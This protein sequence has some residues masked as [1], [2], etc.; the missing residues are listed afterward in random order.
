[1]FPPRTAALAI[2][3]SLAACGPRIDGDVAVNETE[4]EVN[5]RSLKSGD[6]V[7]VVGVEVPPVTATHKYVTLKIPAENIGEG[8]HKLEVQVQ[9]GAK[10]KSKS[11]DVNVPAS[12]LAPYL[13][14]FC[15]SHKDAPGRSKISGAAVPG[16]LKSPSCPLTSG[17][18]VA[19]RVETHADAVLTQDGAVIAHDPSGEA[20]LSLQPALK[21]ASLR[22]VGDTK[23]GGEFPFDSVLSVSRGGKTQSFPLHVELSLRDLRKV[24]FE[25]VL[26]V[27]PG[28]PVLWPR[29][30]STGKPR[31]VAFALRT[32][33]VTV[34]GKQRAVRPEAYA[35]PLVAGT[36]H[37]ADEVDRFAVATPTDVTKLKSCTGYR[38]ISGS[39]GVRNV[40]FKFGF[41]VKVFD[42]EGK[43]VAERS[44]TKPAKTRCPDYLSGKPGETKV[45]VWGPDRE[46]V[47]QWLESLVR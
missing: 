3:L 21:R 33:E 16:Y 47:Q 36:E 42:A 19:V 30:A 27:E 41:D 6:V 12:A 32:F 1:M 11:F 15:G 28:K 26:A 22:G 45:L 13:R 2:A 29:A 44:F 43:Q 35:S 17:G 7:S 39:G 9:R 10:T 4:V 34:A 40:G 18:G 23:L 46:P 31:G 8:A 37:K 38:T 5:L 25:S 24:L 14:V 20:Q